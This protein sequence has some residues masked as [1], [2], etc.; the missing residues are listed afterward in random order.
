MTYHSSPYAAYGSTREYGQAYLPDL[1][2]YRDQ[3]PEPDAPKE[4]G[5]ETT[6]DPI[7]RLSGLKFNFTYKTKDLLQ[8]LVQERETIR[9]HAHGQIVTRLDGLR[10]EIS[11][12]SFMNYGQQ[13]SREQAELE[14]EKSRLEQ[15]LCIT[16]LNSWR[17]T[18]QIRER[19]IYADMKHQK[20]ELQIDMM[21][22]PSD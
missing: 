9:Q 1:S 2:R 16:D 3:S 20:T 12:L 7:E 13:P 17:D 11:V 18:T 5:I 6:K 21:E 19:L 15:E 10:Q 8:K 22:E 14:R 4:R